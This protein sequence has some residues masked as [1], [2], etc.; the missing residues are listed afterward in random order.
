MRGRGEVVTWDL[1]MFVI[2]LH[3]Y[4]QSRLTGLRGLPNFCV[5][6]KFTLKLARF[7]CICDGFSIELYSI[8]FLAF[9]LV[10]Y[11]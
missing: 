3:F 2:S 7:K 9:W 10:P 8:C 4:V 5:C 1:F 6:V 11:W